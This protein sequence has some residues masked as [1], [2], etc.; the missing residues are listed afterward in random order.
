MI[1]NSEQSTPLGES[2]VDDV[3]AVREAI[4]EEVGHDLRKLVEQA[5]RKSAEVRQQYG[6]IVAE[7]PVG[8]AKDA[9]HLP[10]K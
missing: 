2:A 3:R 1:H 7:S 10:Q 4:D 6:M 8:V 9:D 5:R